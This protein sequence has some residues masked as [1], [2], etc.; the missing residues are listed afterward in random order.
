[1]GMQWL[2]T[3]PSVAL[4]VIMMSV[5]TV[6][7]Y[8]MTFL[9]TTPQAILQVALLLGG[10]DPS[11]P[12]LM[13]GMFLENIDEV[14]RFGRCP[15]HPMHR[16]GIG[17]ARGSTAKTVGVTERQGNSFFRSCLKNPNQRGCDTL[18]VRRREEQEAEAMKVV[19]RAAANPHFSFTG[20]EATLAFQLANR[21]MLIDYVIREQAPQEDSEQRVRTSLDGTHDVVSKETCVYCPVFSGDVTSYASDPAMEVF[22]TNVWYLRSP[23]HATHA[24]VCYP[25]CEGQLSVLGRVKLYLWRLYIRMA[26][27]TRL[28]ALLYNHQGTVRVLTFMLALLYA[29]IYRYT[30]PPSPL[31]VM[32]QNIQLQHQQQHQAYLGLVGGMSPFT[33]VPPSNGGGSRGSTLASHVT[34]SSKHTRVGRGKKR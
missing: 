29:C 3:I 7:R 11:S 2:S 10:S 4:I 28:N 13:C 27:R 8:E 25:I 23:A 1:M 24:K 17:D 32:Q 16:G 33:G 18:F 31:V 22:F 34:T 19:E 14:Q 20:Q 21:Q 9:P 12:C 26:V 5:F 15:Y 6:S 30:L